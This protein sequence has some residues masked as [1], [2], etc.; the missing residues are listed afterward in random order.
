MILVFNSLFF[1]FFRGGQ[2]IYKDN[3]GDCTDVNRC[4]TYIFGELDDN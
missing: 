4:T 1:F 3:G 2:S